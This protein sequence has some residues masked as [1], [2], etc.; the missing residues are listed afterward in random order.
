MR[1]TVPLNPESL[2]HWT[3]IAAPAAAGTKPAS[4]ELPG[5]PR[6]YF[7]ANVTARHHPDPEQ[8][9]LDI[10]LVEYV[11]LTREEMGWGAS[12]G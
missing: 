5:D 4:V 10:R 2:A 11:P 1:L 9:R 8:A 12:R 7:V 3:A 6:Q